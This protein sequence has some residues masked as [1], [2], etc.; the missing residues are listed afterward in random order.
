MSRLNENFSASLDPFVLD[1][2]EAEMDLRRPNREAIESLALALSDHYDGQ[3]LAPPFEGIV[4]SA[5]GVGKTYVL[6]GAMEYLVQ[7]RGIRNFAVITP[8][9][10]ILTKTV[11]NFTHGHPKSLL[12]AMNIRPLVVTAEN[13]S[14]PV[15]RV[16]MDD[17]DQVKLY[18]FTVQSLTRPNTEAG[19]RTHK[20]QEGLGAAFYAYLQALSDL[21]VFADEHHCYYGPAFSKAIRDLH[22]F[23]LIGLTA[24]PHSKTP[25]DQIIY[26]YPL[27]AAVADRLVK[28]PVLVGR[29]D[30]RT[31]PETK[32]ND[33]ARL[34]E[35]KSE[36]M[37]RW[38]KD[39]HH[40]PVRPV[41]L[42]VA[43]T[44]AEADEYAEILQSPVFRQGRYACPGTVLVV[45]SA[46]SDD[47]LAQLDAVEDPASP[48]RVIVSVGMLKEGWDVKNVYVICSMRASVSEILTEQTLGRGLR[49]PFGTYTNEELLD[50]L[51]VVAHERYDD[52]LRRAGLLSQELI[53][54]R[55]RTVSQPDGS[56][57]RQSH[58]VMGGVFPASDPDTTDLQG[59]QET[60]DHESDA[61]DNDELGS[62]P[63][64]P[65]SEIS[66]VFR[67]EDPETRERAADT[68]SSVLQPRSGYPP[69]VVPILRS[70]QEKRIGSLVMVVAAG[71]E[72]F[73]ALGRQLAVNPED[74]L[75]RMLVQAT[76]V[77]GKDG[78]KHTEFHTV[79]AQQP[80]SSLGLRFPLE[81][82]RARLVDAVLGA[83]FVMA[84][85]EEIAAAGKIVDA[86]VEGL[87][88]DVEALLSAY[89]QRASAR[90]LM[91]VKEAVRVAVAQ[92][93]YVEMVFAYQLARDRI[94]PS[95]AVS[96]DRFGPFIRRQRYTGW[97][98]SLY[99]E[100][101]FDSSPERDVANMLDASG[102]VQ[103]WVRLH[104]GDLKILWQDEA[105]SARWYN[106]DFVAI[107]YDE[108]HWII[109]V[110]ADNDLRD[111]DVQRK[112]QAAHHWATRASLDPQ[113]GQQWRYLLVSETDVDSVRG[114]WP[115]LKQL[116][117]E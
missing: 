54:Y 107:S 11:A 71:L 20:F 29:K 4:V 91:G 76:V 28:T 73:K 77:E 15:V 19:R 83:P 23:A 95:T 63:R 115:A 60:S 26:R 56:T 105:G 38:C 89:L 58:P 17:P 50:T 40:K 80:V 69:I 97:L 100:A 2:I 5:T 49:L 41:M 99:D 79:E 101:W 117:V 43:E 75:R 67:V 24:T 102:D 113:I 13:F 61:P 98:R 108:T 94:A 112:R 53:E 68:D 66:A 31:D 30:D 110:K 34:L 36:V 44:I 14:S 92:P 9:K 93:R 42:V 32:L 18:V 35:L 85:P 16:A 88:G 7:D 96:A 21:V 27:A 86:F 114:S 116:A 103:V 57:E 87:N 106:P 65:L 47:A 48:V 90:L 70:E 84:R 37:E 12:P 64:L 111:V 1:Q 78:L 62:K 25:T 22:P 46:S 82:S 10:T 39:S 52:L 81:D 55:V 45:T 104:R 8:G 6:A 59:I 51:E 74:N 109:E 33:G 3:R 72:Q